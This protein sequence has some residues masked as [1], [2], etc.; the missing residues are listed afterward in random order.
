MKLGIFTSGY[1]R[2]SLEFAF[3]DAK[4]FGYDYIELWGGRPHAYAP[5]LKAGDIEQIKKLIDKY[6]I[7]V[8]GY[9]PEHNAYPYNF[10]IGTE[11]MR[12][13][14]VAYLK[15]S[16]DMAKAMGAAFMLISPAHGGYTATVR[17]IRERLIK[18]IKELGDY[19]D[20]INLDVVVETLTPLETNVCKNANDL[21]EIFS[22]VPSP[23][24]KG[25]LDVVVPFI[26][27]ESITA[28][29]DILGDKFY[30]LHLVDSDGTTDT[31]VCPGEGVLPLK[32]LVGEIQQR[33]Y[34]GTATIEL[35]T[36]YIHEPRFYARRAIEYIRDL[37]K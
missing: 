23:R 10:M 6:Q 7:P 21:M 11:A 34:K 22:Q 4:Q 35:V 37:M 36:A 27:H 16:M 3:Q 33:G 28:Y 9:T 31:H 13:D 18:T 17:E 1:Q 24:L 15:L 30:H 20:K 14:A 25:M 8:L 12:Q 29:F 32:E 19:A 2:S 26:Q 5:D